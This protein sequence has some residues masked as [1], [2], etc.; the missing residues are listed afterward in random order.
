[1]ARMLLLAALK[2]AVLPSSSRARNSDI[3]LGSPSNPYVHI[4]AIDGSTGKMFFK[5]VKLKTGPDLKAMFLALF[6][7]P[8]AVIR[9]PTYRPVNLPSIHSMG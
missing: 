9:Q 5:K 8:N 6:S 4:I 1:M 3:M 7:I 2:T